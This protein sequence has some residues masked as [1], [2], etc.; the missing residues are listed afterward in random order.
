M[1]A[2][3]VEEDERERSWSGSGGPSCRNERSDC[4]RLEGE[5]ARAWAACV[6]AENREERGSGK[7]SSAIVTA[8]PQEERK[9]KKAHR[10]KLRR[11]D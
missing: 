6:S 10:P 1:C 3:V 4:R 2:T 5:A 9:A 11:R 8:I 7:S